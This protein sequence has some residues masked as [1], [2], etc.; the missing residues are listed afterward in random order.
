MRRRG[1]GDDFLKLWAGQSVSLVGARLTMLALPLTAI[2]LFRAGPGQIGLL[3]G[4][5]FAPYVL[6]SLVAGVWVDRLERRP[7]LIAT[8]VGLA[9]VVAWVPIAHTAGALRLEQ[10]YVVSFVSGTLVVLFNV[11][12]QSYLPELLSREDLIEGN[13]R[14]EISRSVAQ[15]AGPGLAGLVIPLLSAPGAVAL[16]AASYAIAALSLVAIRRRP[17]PP[18]AAGR[19]RGIL[20]ELLEGLGF[21][22]GSRALAA[23]A[24][25]GGVSNLGQFAQMT[26]LLLYLTNQLHL[27]VGAVGLVVGAAGLPSL[28]GAIVAA[29]TAG[30]VGVGR[31]LAA[32]QFV[33]G[34]GCL[35]LPLAAGPPT[36]LVGLLV[37]AG[38]LQGLSSSIYNVNQVSLRQS[39]TP[40]RLQGRVNATMRFVLW[41]TIP[42]G[43]L[44][45]GLLGQE[46]GLR[47]TL[48]VGAALTIGSAAFLMP[49]GLLAMRR[50]P[51]AD[52]TSLDA[53]SGRS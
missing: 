36:V 11:A 6:F 53:R 41:G 37:L 7:I 27:S 44:V 13:R 43:S 26:V 29:R 10:L 3:N 20:G 8:N 50:L 52:L 31:S 35:L 16:N 33:L 46:I 42:L 4:F 38:G 23:L 34:A 5:Q 1:L 28:L 25:C 47:A 2:L 45:G 9:L 12:Y 30:L 22:A 40:D 51:E 21:V 48:V 19:P 17:A 18:R 14:L 39:M 49:S 32:A 15:T 24:L